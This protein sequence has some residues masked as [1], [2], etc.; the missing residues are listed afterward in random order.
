[1]AVDIT[2]MTPLIQVFNKRTA[3]AFYRALHGRR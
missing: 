2:G 1:M 3:V